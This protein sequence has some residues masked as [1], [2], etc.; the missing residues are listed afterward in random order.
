MA[1]LNRL[2]GLLAILGGLAWVIKGGA[3]LLTGWQPPVLLEVGSTLFL[4]ALI[5]L[6][7]R[8][9]DAGALRPAG[10]IAAWVGLA[11]TLGLAVLALVRPDSLPDGSAF[12]FPGSLF[13]LLSALGL[14]AALI[15]LGLAGKRSGVPAPPWHNF[16]LYMGIALLP[17]QLIGA[18]LSL[19][20]ERLLEIPVV[21]FGLAW[22]VLGTR[23]P[24]R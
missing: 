1:A 16:T 18:L 17:L 20:G 3:I 9:Y 15:L 10:L 24:R 4:L 6:A 2:A 8:I 12:T 21:L 7:G 13:Y 19:I 22:I 5:G 11:S 14:L 23:L